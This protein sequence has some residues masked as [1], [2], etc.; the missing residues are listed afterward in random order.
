MHAHVRP[1]STKGCVGWRAPGRLSREGAGELGP[2]P[3][4]AGLNDCFAGLEWVHRNRTRLNISKV[5]IS[6]PS[7][8]GNLCLATAMK[9][10][11]EFINTFHCRF[12]IIF[13]STAFNFS[14]N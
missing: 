6:G 10:K 4:P 11:V 3:F 14:L 12:K 9:A 8:G 7:G 2:H 1:I 5:I 13:F